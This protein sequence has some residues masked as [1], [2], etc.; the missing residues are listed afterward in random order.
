MIL[1]LT[2]NN[3]WVLNNTSPAFL[4]SGVL[5]SKIAL[6]NYFVISSQL[7]FLIKIKLSFLPCLIDIIPA[8]SKGSFDL[9]HPCT[10][11]GWSTT[12]QPTCKSRSGLYWPLWAGSSQVGGPAVCARR[13]LRGVMH[14]C[15][16]SYW[17]SK[18]S[19]LSVIN[20]RVTILRLPMYLLYKFCVISNKCWLMLQLQP[21]ALVNTFSSSTDCCLV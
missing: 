3:S 10:L 18:R 1:V 15:V 20:A 7:E 2:D 19:K 5:C 16:V 12:C 9:L 8:K 4:L 17:E 13:L 14:R 11:V 21:S 6:R